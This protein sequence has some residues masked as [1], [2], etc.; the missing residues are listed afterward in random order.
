MKKTALFFLYL[1]LAPAV[2]WA[3]QGAAP[4]MFGVNEV[5]VDY[6]HFDDPAAAASCS[7][8]RDDVAAVLAKAFAGSGVPAVA[9]VDAKPVVVGTARINLIPE[10]SSYLD[11]NLGCMSWASLSAESRSKVVVMPV[12]TLRSETVI[13]WRQH[14]LVVSGQ[15]IHVRMV[16]DAL[17]KMAAQ[18]I[19]EYR[20]DQPPEIKQ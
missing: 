17:Q 9:A 13:Y 15:S 14:T 3:Q 8:S 11:E 2:S 12:S 18:F 4:E 10:I 1:G 6:A 19:Q 5:I 20:I 7:L 16:D